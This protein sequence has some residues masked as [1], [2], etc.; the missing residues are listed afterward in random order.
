MGESDA[1]RPCD[2]QKARIQHLVIYNALVGMVRLGGR[3]IDDLREFRVGGR[4]AIR[5]QCAG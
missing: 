2:R 4:V 3:G 1:A 5:L